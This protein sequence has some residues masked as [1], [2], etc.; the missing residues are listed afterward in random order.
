M[1]NWFG[2][3][4]LSD[5]VGIMRFKVYK[6][7]KGNIFFKIDGENCLCQTKVLYFKSLLYDHN[8]YFLLILILL[9][10]KV[11]VRKWIL[12]RSGLQNL[13]CLQNLLKQTNGTDINNLQCYTKLHL[14]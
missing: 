12:F 4:T 7:Q 9:T 3:T 5:S 11:L 14:K 13:N 6:N 2:T 8:F 1:Q 10:T